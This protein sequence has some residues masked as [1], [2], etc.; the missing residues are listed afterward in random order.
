MANEISLKE[1]ERKVFASTVQDGLWDIL[2]GC[3]MLEFA[4]GPLLSQSLGDFWSSA[5]F[6]PFWGLVYLAILYLR[7]YIISPGF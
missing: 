1:A 2:V 5:V 3:V 6:L 7:K 4:I